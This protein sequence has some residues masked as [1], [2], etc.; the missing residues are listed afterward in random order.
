M[1]R[2][3]TCFSPLR[4][5]IIVFHAV[6]YHRHADN[7]IPFFWL[8]RGAVHFHVSRHNRFCH[9][10]VS[11]V[12]YQKS[13]SFLHL[14]ICCIET[15]RNWSAHLLAHWRAGK[16]KLHREWYEKTMYHTPRA[17]APRHVFRMHQL[18]TQIMYRL[19]MYQQACGQFHN[20][21]LWNIW[22]HWAMFNLLPLIHLVFTGYTS[23]SVSHVNL[24]CGSGAPVEL[25]SVESITISMVYLSIDKE[26]LIN[27]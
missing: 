17:C 20:C 22:R 24:S 14:T 25:L 10:S 19:S 13:I 5:D 2:H 3:G 9:T 1:V 12:S 27:W 16:K 7:W 11:C 18:S 4:S 26:K 8:I 6:E 21:H 23:V 15:R